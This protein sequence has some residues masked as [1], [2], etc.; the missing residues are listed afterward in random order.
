MTIGNAMAKRFQ[1]KKFTVT[2]DAHFVAVYKSKQVIVTVVNGTGGGTFEKGTSVTVTATVPQNKEFDYWSINDEKVSTQNPCTFTANENVTITAHFKYGKFVKTTEFTMDDSD[3]VV[4]NFTDIHVDNVAFLSNTG[5]V[6]KTIKYAIE[7]SKPD[8]LLFSGDL[9]GSASDMTIVCNYLDG[10]KIPYFVILG[11]HDH[12]GSLGFNT[13]SQCLNQSQYGNIE[14]GP[15]D[16]GSQGNYTIKIKNQNNQL[17][18][19]FVMMDT[20][21]KYTVTDDSLVE[22]V[23]NP[24]SGVSYGSFNGKKTY[25]APGWNGLRGNQ[26]DWYED[27]VTELGCETTLV[28]HIPFL[29]YCK[30]Y[31]QYQDAKNRGDQTALAACAPVGHCNMKEPMCGSI[32]NLGLFDR[33]KQCGSTKN[34]ICGHDHVNDFSLLYEGVRL[35]YSVKTGEG[36]YWQDDGS[37]CGYT[38]LTIDGA[39]KASLDQIYY[40]PLNN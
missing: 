22:Y 36:A 32:E 40:N 11:N 15:N 39:G 31:E 38:E 26:I 37:I 33:I 9:A 34:V 14:M 25:C 19:G 10:F 3:F 28:C 20:G 21:N 18:H 29:E 35:T 6:S 7:R 5:T 1:I 17:V 2:E 12:E 27:T 8:L 16:L 4:L 23:T 13:I 24:I 30:A